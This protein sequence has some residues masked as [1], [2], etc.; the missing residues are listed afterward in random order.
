VVRI[1]GNFP[2][3]ETSQLGSPQSIEENRQL[4]IG[5]AEFARNAPA[6]RIDAEPAYIGRGEREERVPLWLWW[7][8]LSLDA[9]TVAA[10]WALLFAHASG[11]AVPAKTIA[12]LA[13]AVWLIY[14]VDR[15]L[16][17]WGSGDL[18]GLQTRHRFC[19]EHRGIV[20][21]LAGGGVLT[22]LWLVLSGVTTAAMDAGLALSGVLAGY[23]VCIHFWRRIGGD[24]LSRL[25]PKEIAVGLLFAAGTSL[26]VWSTRETVTW[27][28]LASWLL[29]GGVC[30]LNCVSIQCWESAGGRSGNCDA[31][32]PL[33]NWAGS[34][35]GYLAGALVMLSFVAHEQL[36]MNGKV[37]AAISLSALLIALLNAGRERV[38]TQGLRVLVDAALFVAAIVALAMGRW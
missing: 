18:R 15:L 8:I 5:A 33:V 32:S 23:M 3:K 21:G 19:A 22:T 27:H 30:A 10:V 17:G 16:D 2:R 12:A 9:P 35:I 11:V 7:N 31:T 4:A 34:R 29:F 1:S 6:L 14:M 20:L 25:L 26:P 38:S 24:P 28:A 36:Q 37:M 13:L